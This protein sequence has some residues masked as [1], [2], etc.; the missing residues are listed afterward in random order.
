MLA[1]GQLFHA[2]AQ[3]QHTP[4]IPNFQ[5]MIF[6]LSQSFIKTSILGGFS[7]IDHILY[8]SLAV[9]GE[10]KDH[11]KCELVG[12]GSVHHVVHYKISEHVA[13]VD[14]SAPVG[15]A[16]ASFR[17]LVTLGEHY[18]RCISYNLLWR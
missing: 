9:V 15:S 17:D 12:G 6:W 4:T 14:C 11:M 18:S 3:R 1:G 5:D 13:I 8:I 16:T 7:Q 10:V 2:I